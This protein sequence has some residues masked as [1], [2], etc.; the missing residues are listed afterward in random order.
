MSELRKDPVTRRWVIIATE[1]ARRPSDFA[2]PKTEEKS[3][4]EHVDNCPFCEGNESLTPPE[5]MAYRHAGTQ[6][7]TKGWWIRVIPNKYSAVKL[8]VPLERR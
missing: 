2:K 1:R 8:D 4:P 7:D 5:L 3:L 6:K